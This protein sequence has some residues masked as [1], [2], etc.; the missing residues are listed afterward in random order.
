M[1]L[2]FLFLAC[3]GTPDEKGGGV[4]TE[5][6]G[7]EAT[8]GSDDGGD[9][10]DG[11]DDGGGDGETGDTAGPLT[12][13]MG[14]STCDPGAIALAPA[15]GEALPSVAFFPVSNGLVAGLY[16]V[17]AAGVPVRYT[18][19]SWGSVSQKGAITA[20]F[21][22][23]SR[24][25]TA[26]TA[27][28]DRL[29]DLY[30]GLRVDGAGAWANGVAP[31]SVGYQPGTGILQVEQT[32][33]GISLTTTMYAP[34]E[35][36]GE[37]DLVVIFTVENTDTMAHEVDLFSLQNVHV[38]GEGAANGESLT[39]VGSA[40]LES[41]GGDV[42]LHSPLGTPTAAAGA[43]GGHAQNPYGRLLSGL[44]LDDGLVS[45]DDVAAG[46][47][48]RLGSLA[49]GASQQRGVVLS[50]GSDGALLSGRVEA[51]LA[52]REAS[53]LLAAEEANWSDWM[54]GATRPDLSGVEAE[55]EGDAAALYDQSLAILRMAQLRD[56]TGAGL[57]LASLPPGIW[58]LS[59]PRD[60]A[61]ATLALARAGKVEEA[62]AAIDA[63]LNSESGAYAGYLGVEDYVVSVCRYTGDGVEESDGA[64]C[65]DG[66]D[67]GP[68]IE[69]DNFGLFLD[70]YAAVAAQMP[71]DW[72]AARR[73]RVEAGVADVLSG[74]IDLNGMLVADSSIW[75]R[76]WE[77][78]FPNGRKQF[79]YSSLHAVSGL[80]A[81]GGYAEA[82]ERVRV[83]GL[84]NNGAV[85]GPVYAADG[86]PIFASAPEE[87]CEYCGPYDISTVD[88][89]VFGVIDPGSALARGT[90]GALDRALGMPNS[91]GLLRSDDGTGT[92][93]PYPWYDDQEWVFADLTMARGLLAA[94]DHLDGAR[95][96]ALQLLSRVTRVGEVNGGLI[97]EL[98]SDGVYTSEDDVDNV[99]LGSDPGSEAQGATPMVGFGAGLYILALH[100]AAGG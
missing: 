68:N 66:S 2:F 70:A 19:G 6:G 27:A 86:C 14:L 10:T 78:C 4:D 1:S 17:D 59:W 45:G 64:T 93:N 21:D 73:P 77:G 79:V 22:H 85:G 71:A 94:Q 40:I 15:L 20:L 95:P 51:W 65:P 76:H 7:G 35:A 25:P 29:W 52:G 33:G 60:Q 96:R 32:V 74:L 30:G 58:S 9:G 89:I 5:G 36:G 56:G 82:A 43:P 16:A 90:L 72:E 67:A 75:E 46:F 92:T 49:P 39:R 31:R 42:V 13:D 55:I 99:R 53:A 26:T 63:I 34:F 88:A 3:A 23:P 38:G 41:R 24:A 69:L 44:D 18:D 61:Y 83:E 57:I 91:A 8:D 50:L 37:R 47:Q 80:R 11:T 48:W 54:A 87:I 81:L 12:E 84:L 97:P 62:A 98:L 100:E 28:R